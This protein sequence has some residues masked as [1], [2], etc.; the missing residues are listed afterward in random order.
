ML[1]K[2][3]L[4]TSLQECKRFLVVNHDPTGELH[5]KNIVY[6]RL[7]GFCKQTECVS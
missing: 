2:E 7:A 4:L 5:G 1:V 3:T 6:Y